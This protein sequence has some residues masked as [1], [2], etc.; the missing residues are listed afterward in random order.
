MSSTSNPTSVLS[1]VLALVALPAFGQLQ[2]P[3][4]PPGNPQTPNKIA[5]GRVLF[6]DEQLSSNRT[7]SCGTC[8]I[9][10]HGGSDPRSLQPTGATHP[11]FDEMFGNADDIQG[12]PGVPLHNSGGLYLL[13]SR[14]GLDRQVTSRH[15]PSSINAGY[16]PSMFWDGRASGPLVDPVTGQTVMPGNAALENQALGP[17]VS[18]VE[19]AHQG[20]QWTEV[21]AQLAASEPLALAHDVP[22][23]MLRFVDGRSYA[24]LFN[25]AFGTP[26]I[27]ASRVAMAIAS[28]E[29]TLFTNQSPFDQFL[30]NNTGL[31]AEE[32]SGRSVFVTASCD[33]C[34]SLA[35]MS[36]HTFKYIGVRPATEDQ[37]RFVQTNL[38]GDLGSMRVPS[39]RNVELR[40]PLMRNGRL[41][42]LEDVV[43]FYNRGGDF[44][45]PNKD[46]LVRPLNLSPQD[47]ADLIAFLK[48]PLTD[49]RLVSES[50][51]FHRPKL[52]TETSRV[53][54]LSGTGVGGSGAAT[55]DA[56]ANEPA[57][58][59]N[60]SFTIA[61]RNGLGGANALLVI[62]DSDP[63]LTP[64]GSGSFAFE[65]IVLSGSGAGNG[66]GSIN[67][68]IP[69]DQAL[70]EKQLF[71]RW[72]V[73]DPGASGGTATSRLVTIKVFR[74][75]SQSV[76]FFDD[77]ETGNTSAW[78]SVSP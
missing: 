65:N 7:V 36:D 17:P 1:T 27:S 58:L 40:V 42:S 44:N 34:H 72:Y 78:S 20:R 59:G 35:I 61:V 41:Q 39:L 47:R 50:A 18:D 56:I 52:F 10:S 69:D 75:L 51:P 22:T 45:A 12:S 73:T 28:Y 31:T 76:V 46:P 74:P 55:P 32:A 71:A 33:R 8:H 16:S 67:L 66:F 54:T 24:D 48:R 57:F 63:G 37:G 43:D 62:N 21:L 5:L 13:S 6:W 68:V 11:G 70:A 29:R 30:S 3:P 64:P 53:P 77:F 2:P 14:F 4:I 60:P 49:P 19:M 26:D 15:S 23:E 9:P 38:P 25:L